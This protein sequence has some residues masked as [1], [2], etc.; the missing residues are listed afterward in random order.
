M[1]RNHRLRGDKDGSQAGLPAPGLGL[2]SAVLIVLKPL[3]KGLTMKR[4][5]LIVAALAA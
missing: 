2:A 4:D 1:K 3:T 5:L